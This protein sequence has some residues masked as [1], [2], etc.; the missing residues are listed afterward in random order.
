MARTGGGLGATLRTGVEAPAEFLNDRQATVLARLRLASVLATGAILTAV[1]V[2][3]LLE[4]AW[5]VGW[6]LGVALQLAICGV[7]YWVTGQRRMDTWA[8]PLAAAFL[9]ALASVLPLTVTIVPAKLDLFVGYLIIV[10]IAAALF[11]PWGARPQATMTLILLGWLFVVFPLGEVSTS[12]ISEAVLLYSVAAFLSVFGAYFLDRY[13]VLAFT[14]REQARSLARDRALLLDVGR[15]LNATTDV[16]ALVDRVVRL[17]RPLLACD[18]VALQLYD[19]NS[20]LMRIAAIDSSG[21]DTSSGA[22]GLEFPPF[23]EL[24]EVLGEG[25]VI[26]LPGDVRVR[27]LEPM[28]RSGSVSQLLIAPM[29]RDGRLLGSLNFIRVG[30]TEPFTMEQRELVHGIANQTAIA[31]TNA[32]LVDDLQKANRVKSEFVST[33]SHELRT[34]LHVILGY[35]EMLDDHVATPDEVVRKVRFAAAELLDLIEAT[36]DLNRLESGRDEPELQPLRVGDLLAELRDEFDAIPRPAG[37]NLSWRIE[38][39]DSVLSTD[40]RKLKIIVKNLLTNALKFT[41]EG[42][43]DIA[44]GRIADVYE[45]SVRDTGEGIDDS[46]LD[47]IFEMFEQ[48]S[49]GDVDQPRPGVG[50]GLYIVRRLADQL[51]ATIDVESELGAGSHFRVRLAC[52]DAPAAREPRPVLSS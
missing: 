35:T 47:S 36:L 5:T 22:V 18:S 28:L 27:A 33:M 31:L 1:L 40:R 30:G 45:V 25:R 29:R 21:D 15:E 4:P 20:N 50:L 16:D 9:I 49:S 37:V 51:G 46:N 3:P 38:A 52:T 6:F 41:T 34:P 19:E 44:A 26:E 14:E 23:P 32:Q 11:F 13:R 8:N 24:L 7:A 42:R 2:S 39:P 17:A 48:A 12:I 10:T 43:I